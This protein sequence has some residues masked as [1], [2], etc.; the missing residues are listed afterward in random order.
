MT[1][2]NQPMPFEQVT[3]G[4]FIARLDKQLPLMYK[5]AMQGQTARPA[6]LAQAQNGVQLLKEKYK[7][8]HHEFVYTITNSN[9]NIYDLAQIEPDKD[10]HWLR[11]Q[12]VSQENR[13]YTQTNFPL[14]RLKKGVKEVLATG[15]PQWVVFRLYNGG[16]SDHEGIAY[17]MD[18]FVNRFDYDGIYNYFFGNE[19]SAVQA[20]APKTSPALVSQKKHPV[21]ITF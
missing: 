15:A 3:V 20:P 13:D 5:I 6:V 19:K 2:D 18:H 21:P 4:E 17:L 1:R 7:S 8:R 16:P 14:L 11:T 9:I 10:T 12:P